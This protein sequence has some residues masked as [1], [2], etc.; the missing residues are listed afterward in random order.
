M[1]VTSQGYNINKQ[2]IAQS[3]FIDEPR[4]IYA[5]K[6][7]LYFA[8]R[9]DPS[10]TALPVQIQLRPMENGFP[11]SK[12]I[13]PGS[14]VSKAAADVTVDTSGP[15]LTP[16]SF[17]FDEPIYLKG[18]EDF[19]LV[20]IADSKDYSLYIAEIDEFQFGSTERRANK[21]PSSGSLFYTQNGV[22]FTPAQ[23]QDLTFRLHRAA[24]KHTT[25]TVSLKNA[26]VP[27]AHLLNPP[28]KTTSGSREVIVKHF[29]HGLQVGNTVRLT[30]IDSAGVG[31]IAASVL[32]RPAGYSVTKVD[33][34]G[35]AFN[36]DSAGVDADSDAIGGGGAVLA[37]KNIPYSVML[38]HVQFIQPIDTNIF[39]A[40]KA[41]TGKSF[42]GGETSFQKKT[43]FDAIK[44]NENNYTIE[45]FLVANDSAE[46]TQGNISGSRS[47]EFQ[48]TMNTVDSNVSP[49]I[50]MQRTSVSL[51]DN[52]ID[53][54]DSAATSGFNVPL[55]YIDE[56]NPNGSAA[57][58]HI[59]KAINLAND[60][61]GLKVLINANKPDGTD[62]QLYFRTATADEQISSKN[63]T[64]ATIEDTIPT[65]NNPAIFEQHTFLIGGKNGSLPAFT[66]FQLKIVFRSTSSVKVPVLSSIRAIA[67]SV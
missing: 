29:N 10:T 54:Q 39:G 32:N 45:P 58:K 9:D 17:V 37:S 47:L 66:S 60:A 5:T 8:T 35:Y 36:V 55:K 57:A 3:F 44:L 46:A 65:N 42:A 61:V 23:S 31:G 22:T 6:I 4:G 15:D 56:T 53:K 14:I 33:W 12:H 27:L 50:D 21:Q 25:G 1:P 52:I 2:P 18:L 24:F 34:S 28:L 62:F 67:M 7:D 13:L 41:T 30:G 38:P 49:M 48:L 43:A 19:A 40:V 64:L 59:M 51:F 11:S 26:S 63:Y 16:T 20:V